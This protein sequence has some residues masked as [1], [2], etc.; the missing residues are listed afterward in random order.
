[1]PANEMEDESH[2]TGRTHTHTHTHTHAR[3]HTHT[4]THTH[5]HTH[6]TAWMTFVSVHEVSF[7]RLGTARRDMWMAKM[8]KM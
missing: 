2:F 8:M 7:L 5:T 1:M 4:Y 3:T 6:T